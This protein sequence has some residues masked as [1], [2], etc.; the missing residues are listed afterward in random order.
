[1]V[2]RYQGAMKAM[3]WRIV[4][5]TY[6]DDVVQ[7]AWLSVVRHLT[8]FEG[9]S[10]LKTWLLVITANA[11]KSHLKRSRH[12]KLFQS[13]DT[14]L[15]LEDMGIFGHRDSPEALL[16]RDEV[17]DHLLTAINRLSAL[18]RAVLL[19]HEKEN[20]SFE[21]ICHRLRISPDN[22][23]VS[24]HRARRKVQRALACRGA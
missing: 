20:L 16:L 10:S 18:H 2:D 19:L 17:G 24:L 11:A 9:R 15:V 3:A 5:P 12:D 7:D 6:A 23:R 4:G 13:V 14:P 1:M 21:A 22:A 8:Q